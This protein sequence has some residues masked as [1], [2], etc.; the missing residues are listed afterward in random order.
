MTKRR[1]F[2]T[3][4][5]DR[6][7]RF[8]TICYTQKIDGKN[9]MRCY[10]RPKYKEFG[11]YAKQLKSLVLALTVETRAISIISIGFLYR[12]DIVS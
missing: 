2:L 8:F 7:K 10:H 6:G 12:D 1:Y 5:A 9:I 4:D 3:N 11:D